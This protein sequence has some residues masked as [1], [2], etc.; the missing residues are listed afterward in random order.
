MDRDEVKNLLGVTKVYFEAFFNICPYT[1]TF[2]RSTKKEEPLVFY[3]QLGAFWIWLSGETLEQTGKYF[4]KNHATILHSV[5]V[6]LTEKDYHYKPF[7]DKIIAENE[8]LFEKD[9]VFIKELMGDN[10]IKKQQYMQNRLLLLEEKIKYI[11]DE[12]ITIKDEL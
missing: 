9:T 11:Q 7:L 3:R 6:V 10:F 5:K 4:N 1:L 12:I 8:K 2:L